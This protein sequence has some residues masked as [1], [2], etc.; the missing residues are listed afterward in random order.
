MDHGSGGFFDLESN[1]KEGLLEKP[2][3]EIFLDNHPT[4]QIANS[5]V[6]ECDDLPLLPHIDI[7][8][9]YIKKAT[10]TKQHRRRLVED[11]FT[12]PWKSKPVNVFVKPSLPHDP[13]AFT[14]IKLFR[15]TAFRLF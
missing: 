12:T 8:A 15:G 6:L 7:T 9:N 4:Q 13:L 14:P 11:V 2:V 5:A 1:C 10:G 3:K